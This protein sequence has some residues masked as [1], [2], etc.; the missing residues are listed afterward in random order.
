MTDT[1]AADPA[2]HNAMKY[3]ATLNDDDVA[4]LIADAESL[5]PEGIEG[6][7]RALVDVQE[8]IERFDT[9]LTAALKAATTG[10]D[11]IAI[12]QQAQAVRDG[13]LAEQR[14]LNTR[15]QNGRY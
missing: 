10:F 8:R 3:I 15:L 13:L 4:T 11:T 7:L 1:S 5:R 14:E 12:K 9:G 6:L 2:R